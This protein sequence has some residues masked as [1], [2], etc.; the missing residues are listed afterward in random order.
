M[1]ETDIEARLIVLELFSMTAMG[2]YLANARNDPDYQ[3][4][5]ALL[6]WL[7]DAVAGE[8]QQAPPPMQKA[9]RDYAQHLT[10]RLRENLRALRGEGGQSH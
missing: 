10:D 6:T 1:T 7:C 2:L 3:K 5:K 8:T 9:A 4:A